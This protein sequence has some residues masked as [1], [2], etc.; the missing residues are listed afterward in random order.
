V[1]LILALLAA[2]P[3]AATLIQVDFTGSVA[4]LPAGLSGDLVEQGDTVI[5]R[6]VYDADVADVNGEDPNR[7][8]YLDAVQSFS[9]SMGGTFSVSMTSPTTFA[10]LND[11]P[12]G[13]PRDA[14]LVNAHQSTTQ[15][16]EGAPINGLVPVRM[17]WGPSTATDL[18]RVLSDAIP[19]VD[20]LLRFLPGD[21]MTNF[22][23]V[24]FEGGDDIRWTQDTITAQVIPEPSTAM[25]LGLGLAGLAH[26]R[27]RQ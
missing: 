16:L 15:Q 20:D 12:L 17:Q 22:N 13:P 2:G 25:L 8:L 1:L 18:T 4:S 21:G 5:G 23:F 26:A 19:G 9:V 10:V 7:G 11:V 3:A 24:S 14:L 6:F 27:R